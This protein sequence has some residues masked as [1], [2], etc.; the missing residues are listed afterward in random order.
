MKKY[1]IILLAAFF[2]TSLII[3]QNTIFTENFGGNYTH[4][5][6]LSNNFSGY[7]HTGTGDFTH[8]IVSGQGA[9]GSKCFGQLDSS[10]VSSV[11]RDLQLFAGNTYEFKAYVKTIQSMI[12]VTLRINVGGVD[13]ATSGNTSA[14][15]SWEELSCTYTPSVDEMASLMFVKTGGQLANIDKI[16]VICTSCPD[17]NYVFDFNDSK[18]GW[19]SGGGSALS[20]GYNAMNIK[21]TGVAAVARSGNLTAD[22]NLNASNYDRARVTFRTPYAAGGAGA[23]K[24]YFYN[25]AAGNATFAVFDLPR[26]LSNTTTFQTVEIDLTSTPT[27]GN[28]SG[29]IA[30]LGFRSPWGISAGDTCFLQKIE[31][32]NQPQVTPSLTLQGIMDFTVPGGGSSGKA[33]HLKATDNILDLSIYGIGVANNGGGT[34]S[35]EYSFPNISVNLGDDILLARDSAEMSMYFDSC[36]SSFHHILLASSDISQNGDDAIELFENAIVIE[37]FGDINVDG[38]GEPWEYMDSWAY[39]LGPTVGATGPNSFSGFDWSFGAV[40]CTDG[41]TTTQTSSCPYPLCGIA[42]PPPATPYNVTLEVNTANIYQNGGS[43]GPNGMYAGGGFLGGSDGLQLVQSTTDT[44]IWSAVATVVSGSNYY[45]FFNSPTSGSD[46]GTKENLNGLPCGDSANYYDRLLPNI[47]SDTTVQHC[48]GSCETDGS[49]PPPPSS[50]VNITFTL[51]VSSIISTGGTIDSTGMFIAGGGTFGNPGDYPMTDLGGGV[52][53]FTVTKPIGFTSDYTFTNGNS[54]WGA[55]E[56][57]SGLPCAFPPYDDRNLAPVYSD[58]TIQH[59]FGTCDYDGTCNSVVTPPTGT[60]VTFQVDMSEVVD[61][62]TAAELNGTFNGWCGNCD[63]MSD[64]DGDS[65]WDVTVSLTPGDSVE[66]KYSADSW[67]IQEMNDPGAPCTNGDST[68]TNRVLVIPASDTVLVVLCWSSCDP[69]VVAPPTGTED[70][71]NNLLIYPNPANNILN[72][73]STEIINK[74]EVLDVVGRVIISKTLNS[75]NYILD[76]SG[77]NNNVYFINYSINGVVKTK[78]VIV[79][80]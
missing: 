74:V 34:D 7:N 12:H 37:T 77:L 67:A 66:Y 53:S 20:I 28:F 42:P 29:P 45:A 25:L 64:A 41:S 1:Y 39:K 22:L 47:M 8:K 57:I 3:A 11:S 14:N 58:T 9:S 70:V 46:W 73:S 35:I 51:N 69:C 48:F 10:G 49:C 60:N 55:K 32:F 2:S 13:V 30:R 72:I 44:L 31:L 38:T 78:K 15:G 5:E 62:F 43:V 76:V 16:K 80:K 56:N 71:L 4:L 24:L 59:C 63:V 54:G 17:Q 26:D 52:W 36:F 6:S 33:I 19:L 27:S 23:G 61:P 75:S 79:N 65:V 50:F 40:N 18:E 21:A 68:Y